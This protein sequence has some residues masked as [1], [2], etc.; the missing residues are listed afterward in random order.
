M[1]RKTEMERKALENSMIGKAPFSYV[2]ISFRNV[3]VNL[4]LKSRLEA[5]VSKFSCFQASSQHDVRLRK[6]HF[7]TSVDVVSYSCLKHVLEGSFMIYS[8]SIHP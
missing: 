8:R 2:C 7:S 1:Q 4:K 3:S 6:L 5:F